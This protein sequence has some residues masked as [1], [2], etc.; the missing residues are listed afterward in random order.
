MAHSYW[1]VTKKNYSS[2]DLYRQIKAELLYCEFLGYNNIM[3]G[4]SVYIC[5]SSVK[6]LSCPPGID[7][8]FHTTSCI[9]NCEHLIL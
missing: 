6:N 3:Y 9:E 2:S 7:F 4:I 1:I 8:T 5:T